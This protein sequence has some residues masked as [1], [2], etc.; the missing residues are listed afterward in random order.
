MAGD[1]LS[2][3]GRPP[4]GLE[5]SLARTADAV[6]SRVQRAPAGAP[7]TQ[8]EK[9]APDLRRCRPRG[10]QTPEPCCEAL[11]VKASPFRALQSAGSDGH[12]R[13]QPITLAPHHR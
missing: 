8:E 7:S 11:R 10:L 1:H 12:Q 2:R 9:R 13:L 5:A 4:R 3:R 6:S